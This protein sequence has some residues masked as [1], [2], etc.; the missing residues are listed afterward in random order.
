MIHTVAHRL[1]LVVFIVIQSFEIAS[2]CFEVLATSFPLN[3]EPGLRH[4]STLKQRR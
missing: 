2:I 4:A 1:N 3:N